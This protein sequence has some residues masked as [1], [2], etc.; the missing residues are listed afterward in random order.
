MIL[1]F[2]FNNWMKHVS[3]WL[4]AVLVEGIGNKISLKK[5]MSVEYKYRLVLCKLFV[6]GL[7]LRCHYYSLSFFTSPGKFTN[8]EYEQVSRISVLCYLES[9]ISK[10]ACPYSYVLHT[11]IC[12]LCLFYP[13]V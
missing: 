12:I 10:K 7:I 1:Y 2:F 11:Y 9:F 8:L 13:L 6:G 5:V 4:S 3:G